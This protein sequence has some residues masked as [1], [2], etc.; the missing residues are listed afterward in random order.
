M[1]RD[2]FRAKKGSIGKKGPDKVRKEKTLKD[3]A[4]WARKGKEITGIFCCTYFVQ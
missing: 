3:I 1:R 2:S 4:R